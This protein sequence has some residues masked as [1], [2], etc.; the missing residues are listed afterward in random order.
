MKIID[1]I[2]DTGYQDALNTL[3]AKMKVVDYWLGP[4]NPDHR[5]TF[6]LLVQDDRSQEVM[7]ALQSILETSGSSR[8]VV[9]PVEAVLPRPEIESKKDSA[10]GGKKKSHTTREELYEDVEKN[11]LL[12]SNHIMLVILSTVVAAIGLLENNVA[13]IIGAMVIA[14]LLGPNIAL[15][16]ATALGDTRLMWEALKTNVVGLGL[17][18]LLSIPIGAIW[19]T[20][21]NSPELLARTHVGIDSIA[22]ALASGAAGV[23]SLTAGLSSVLVGVM[24]AVALLPPT[25]TVGIMLGAGKL[26][27][28]GGAALLLA[29]NII[30]VNL[31]AKL[32]FL[33]RGIKPRTGED[34]AKARQSMTAYIIFW[35]IS[36]AV[37]LFLILQGRG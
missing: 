26:N 27:L 29:T 35:A 25:A 8:I 10:N 7:D 20:Y 18:L 3:A 2:A 17:A 24:V 14:P 1:V 15:A 21:L 22:L 37:I 36:L 33:M 6:R 28:A 4:E 31:S 5:R 23:L 34:I 16:L 11:A 19:P 32:V 13:V 12:D 30:C 9:I